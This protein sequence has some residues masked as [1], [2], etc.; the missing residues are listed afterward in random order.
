MKDYPLTDDLAADAPEERN[1][2]TAK[3]IARRH[4]W[5]A[6]DMSGQGL[7][8]LALQLFGQYNFLTKLFLDG[9]RLRHLPPF[10]GRLKSLAYLDV[11]Q[12]ELVELPS[13]MGMLVNLKTLLLFDNQVQDLPIELGHLYKLE[14]LGIE[15]NPLNVDLK[16]HIMKN[17]TQSLIT[18]LRETRTGK[19]TV[20]DASSVTRHCRRVSADQRSSWCPS[21]RSRMAYC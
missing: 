15:G 21:E 19:F 13:E 4:N 8:A 17:G 1:R 14:V 6:I 7:Q 16:N 10:I 12:N 5:D 3:Q 2:A 20:G 11:S 18:T 9:N